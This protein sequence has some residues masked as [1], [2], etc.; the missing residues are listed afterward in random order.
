M[1]KLDPFKDA[2]A[3]AL[4]F[5][6]GLHFERIFYGWALYHCGHFIGI[7]KNSVLYLRTNRLTRLNYLRMGM[8]PLDPKDQVQKRFYQ[9]PGAVVG[10]RRELTRWV[11]EAAAIPYTVPRPEGEYRGG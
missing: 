11:H 6:A 10:S 4:Q 1:E 9:V 3:D 5:T 7:I 8:Q 2:V